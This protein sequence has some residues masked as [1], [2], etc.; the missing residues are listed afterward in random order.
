MVVMK[1]HFVQAS[2]VKH[3]PAQ[4]TVHEML[5]FVLGEVRRIR[6]LSLREETA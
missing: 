5:F 2:A 3:F 6:L 1:Q 4:Q